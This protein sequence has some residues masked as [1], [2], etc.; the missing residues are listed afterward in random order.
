[1]AVW[2]Y[3]LFLVATRPVDVDALRMRLSQL[4]PP[5]TSPSPRLLLWGTP[6]GD[7][8]D[9]WTDH[10]PSELLVRLDARADDVPLVPSVIAVANEFGLQLKNADDLEIQATAAAVL[11][12]LKSSPAWYAARHPQDE[13]EEDD[14]D[15]AKE[16]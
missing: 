11:A 16:A 1:M 4:L 14:N 7:R 10:T 9:F 8:I 12:D 13:D 2:Q 15:A 3:D 6:E 5:L